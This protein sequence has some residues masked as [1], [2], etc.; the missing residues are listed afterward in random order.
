MNVAHLLHN[1]AIIVGI[2][3]EFWTY[4][5]FVPKALYILI[6]NKLTKEHLG[7]GEF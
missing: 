6:H 4:H 3:G 2:T 1:Y 5:Y 7:L